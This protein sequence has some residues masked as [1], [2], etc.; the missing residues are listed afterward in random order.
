LLVVVLE[1]MVQ[2]LVA[3]EQV[4]QALEDIENHQVLLLVVIQFLL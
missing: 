4:Q 3:M 1:E 2:V